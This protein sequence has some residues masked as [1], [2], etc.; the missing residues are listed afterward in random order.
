MPY[1]GDYHGVEG[2]VD[3]AIAMSSY[4]D[5]VDV[6]DPVIIEGEGGVVVVTSTLRTRSRKSGE[7]MLKP[8]CQVMKIKDGKLVEIRPYYWNVPDYVKLAKGEKVAGN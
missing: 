7:E 8:M 5:V 4:F 3:W 1:G 6:R 2:F